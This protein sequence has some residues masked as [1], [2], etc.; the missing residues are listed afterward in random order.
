VTVYATLLGE[1]SRSERNS[2]LA[3]LLSW[4]LDQYRIVRLIGTDRV[5]AWALAPY[6]RPSVGL[7]AARP[8]VQV[9]RVRRPLVQRVIAPAT[10]S[11]PV[12]R[13]ARLGR[14][15]VWAGTKLLA[16]VPLVAARS[17]GKPGLVGRAEWYAGRAVKKFWSWL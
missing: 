7:V 9:V 6:G 14:I 17:I 4:G 8:I 15:E 12:R 13:G 11:L 10:V 1:P 5:Y 16:S 2:D 3:A